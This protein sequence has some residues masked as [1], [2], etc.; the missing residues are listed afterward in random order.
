MVISPRLIAIALVAACVSALAAALT[1]QFVFGLRPCVLC[2]AQR[3]PFVLAA[4]LAAVS[5]RRSASPS[6]GQLLIR[7][8]GLVLLINACIAF[9]HVG[10]EQHWWASAVCP[11]SN[12]GPLAVADMLA[13]LNRPAEVHCD[14]PQWSFH[15]ITMAAL[16]LPY[17]AGLGL[18]ALVLT[19]RN[20]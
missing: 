11:A 13:E 14:Q 8:A 16:N 15:G 18:L 7:L 6:L 12:D 20:S 1:G 19:R 2:H 10:V 9:Y 17:S 5:L 4:L 3:V